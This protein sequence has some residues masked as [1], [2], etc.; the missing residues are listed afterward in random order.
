[1]RSAVVR[2]AV[3]ASAADPWHGRFQRH[4]GRSRHGAGWSAL[5]TMQPAGGR[6]GHR[7]TTTGCAHAGGVT[8]ISRWSAPKARHHRSCGMTGHAPRRGA[9]RV[10]L[11]EWTRPLRGRSDCGHG[12]RW[13]RAFGAYHRLISITPPAWLRPARSLTELQAFH[14]FELTQPL[15]ERSHRQV[16]SFP[17]DLDH[18]TI[19]E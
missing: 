3:A 7:S 1:M 14:T 6:S 9:V 18:Q 2:G 13:W 8:E 12:I 5:P 4:A 11:R 16:A 17:R 19:A 15:V 10:E